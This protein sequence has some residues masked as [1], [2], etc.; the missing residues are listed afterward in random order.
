VRDY[1]LPRADPPLP[2][3][4][5]APAAPGSNWR[6]IRSSSIG[7]GI[8]AFLLAGEAVEGAQEDGPTIRMAAFVL[9][10]LLC[11]A[12]SL[13]HALVLRRARRELHRLRG[14]G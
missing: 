8:V 12:L 5:S 11:A 2:G 7:W 14:E 4:A 9:L 13:R 3:S 6:A 10:A 1:F